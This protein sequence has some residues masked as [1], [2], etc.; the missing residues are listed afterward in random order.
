[1]NELEPKKEDFKKKQRSAYENNEVQTNEVQTNALQTNEVERQEQRIIQHHIDGFWEANSESESESSMEE[2]LFSDAKFSSGT[3]ANKRKSKSLSFRKLKRKIHRQYDMNIVHKYS[4]ALDVFVRYIQCYH[5][6]YS[7]ASYFCNCKLNMFMLPCMFLS[8]SCSVMTSF[9]FKSI[10]ETLML[11]TLNGIITFLL[12]IINYL[13]LDA[14]AEAHKISAYQYSK[15]KAQIEFSSGE[16]LLNDNDLFLSDNYYISDQMKQWDKHNASL[17]DSKE[18]FYKERCRKYD[19]LTSVKAQKEKFFIERVEKIMVGIKESLKNIEDNNHFAL[20]QHIINKY[21][22]IYNMNIFLYIKSIDSYKNVLLNDLRNVKNEIRFYTN[23]LDEEEINGSLKEKY[24]SLYN[25]K[26]QLLR[27]FF[28]LNKGYTLI[29]SMLQQEILNI[30]LFNKYWFLF[31]LQNFVRCLLF[32]CGCCHTNF[33]ILPEMY[34]KSTEI[35][36]KD[37]DG[38]Y[39]LDKVLRH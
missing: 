2:P 33:H 36:Y 32:C 1:M 3:T 35:G 4:T 24:L 26:N 14:N 39:L 21:S 37:E 16:V 18:T 27:D 28:E 6:L 5:T 25:K 23:T 31:Y 15:L 11:S 34:K 7:E 22:T 29:D 38:I 13:K 8:T 9:K 12:A 19:E 30:E 10:R 17:F 20:P